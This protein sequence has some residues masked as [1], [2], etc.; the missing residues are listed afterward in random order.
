MSPVN[1]NDQNVSNEEVT[2]AASA[3][4]NAEEKAVET[5]ASSSASAAA[6]A[7]PTK[8]DGSITRRHFLTGV[9]GL[10]IAAILAGIGSQ[11]FQLDDTTYAVQVSGGYLLVDSKKCAGCETCMLA[12]SV[13]HNGGSNRNLARIQIRKNPFGSY[14]TEIVQNQCHQCPEP[15]CVAACPTGAMHVDDE[16]G[17]RM[18]TE[19]KCIGCEHCVAACPFTPSRVQWNYEAHHAQ[20]CDLCKNTPFWNH[21]GGPG[22]EQAC[23]S[24]CPLRA[25]KFTTELPEQTAKGYDVN[26]RNEHF[27]MIGF[28]IDDD[29]AVLPCVSV[30]PT[31]DVLA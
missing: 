25:L 19:E 27:A 12:C 3:V 6:V 13:A 14:P 30:P 18:V 1:P 31:P 23:V 21:E 11:F 26:M 29:G 8:R 4:E 24:A 20:K 5:E 17:A 22:G 2:A 10:G 15:Q 16:T 9:G 7:S 28:P